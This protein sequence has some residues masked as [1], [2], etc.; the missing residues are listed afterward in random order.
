MWPFKE[1]SEKDI[2]REKIIK[3]WREHPEEWVFTFKD[4]GRAVEGNHL[5]EGSA[6]NGTLYITHW[7]CGGCWR[8]KCEGIE[9]KGNLLG[10]GKMCDEFHSALSYNLMRMDNH[11]ASALIKKM[12]E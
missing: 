8:F 11:K 3:S 12:E 9:W 7:S 10:G 6:S 1:K 4:S 2:L 5:F